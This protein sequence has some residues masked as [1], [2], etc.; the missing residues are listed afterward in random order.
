M[1]KDATSALTSF[2]YYWFDVQNYVMQTGDAAPLQQL[3]DPA[4]TYCNESAALLEALYNDGGWML[5]GQPKVLNVYPAEA[6]ADGSH[7]AILAYRADA[8]TTYAKDGSE[9]ASTPFQ[10]KSTL[11]TI[12]A[13]YTGGA[14]RC[15]G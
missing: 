13:K 5:G 7:Q 1:D 10:A 6:A 11:M 9:A 2:S 15:F 4:C 12:Q 3:S 14:W 8:S